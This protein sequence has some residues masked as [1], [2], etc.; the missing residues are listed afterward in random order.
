MTVTL[1]EG[2]LASLASSFG[3]DDADDEIRSAYGPNFERLAEVKR[4]YDPDNV[5]RSNHNIEPANA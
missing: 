5:F 1:D 4:R 2:R 3:D